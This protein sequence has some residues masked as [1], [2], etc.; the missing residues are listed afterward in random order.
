MTYT[1]EA[2]KI[3]QTLAK[4]GK[5]SITVSLVAYANDLDFE[6]NRP[7]CQVTV[8]V[9]DPEQSGAVV[10]TD[11]GDIQTTTVP[12]SRHFKIKVQTLAKSLRSLTP[13]PKHR[14]L[15]VDIRVDP[16]GGYENYYEPDV[17]IKGLVIEAGASIDRNVSLKPKYQGSRFDLPF[18]HLDKR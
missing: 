1:D 5:A 6:K 10:Q 2:A 3:A 7:S 11:I 18:V 12:Y 8:T 17:S 4:Q 14:S 13:W 16:I 15:K 9:H